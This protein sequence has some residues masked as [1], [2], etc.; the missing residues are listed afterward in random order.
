MSQPSKATWAPLRRPWPTP[1][2]AGPL[3]PIRMAPPAVPA[4]SKAS[5]LS[6]LMAMV[7]PTT[8]AHFSEAYGWAFPE[9]AQ[10]G[11][12]FSL[13]GGHSAKAR[14]ASLR[15]PADLLDFH[16]TACACWNVREDS[17]MLMLMM[18]MLI[19]L[20]LMLMLMLNVRS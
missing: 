4:L 16:W 18:L 13:S 8:G 1:D 10:P 20:I 6:N 2:Q 7:L 5:K 17:L 15:C 3:D 9:H 14:R 19:M 12:L 11:C